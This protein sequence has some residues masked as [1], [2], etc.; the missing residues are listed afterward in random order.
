MSGKCGVSCPSVGGQA[1]L[2]A[3]MLFLISDRPAALLSLLLTQAEGPVMFKNKPASCPPSPRPSVF[4]HF[5][6]FRRAG[7]K[8]AFQERMRK[9]V[10]T[11]AEVAQK[12]LVWPINCPDL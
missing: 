9:L 12:T 3:S 10:L 1:A 4:L 8:V 2:N 11:L 5:R 7:S 6:M